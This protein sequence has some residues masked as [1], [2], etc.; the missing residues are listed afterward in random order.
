M[1]I[2]KYDALSQLTTKFKFQYNFDKDKIDEGRFSETFYLPSEYMVDSFKS[3]LAGSASEI[4]GSDFNQI[5]ERVP[6]LIQCE[7]GSHF[8]EARCHG[9]VFES[10]VYENIDYDR[11]VNLLDVEIRKRYRG[12]SI[13][14]SVPTTLSHR[15]GSM[16][17]K[18]VGNWHVTEY[19]KEQDIGHLFDNERRFDF[20]RSLLVKSYALEEM[21]REI[22]EG[23]H[24]W[25]H[26][27]SGGVL[28][29]AE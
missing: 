12:G 18:L 5:F 8:G 2:P 17:E 10:N 7:E 20:C 4:G 26:D 9:V 3:V 27:R 14:E 11:I 21:L 29:T 28:Q 19:E 23:D 22:D 16:G 15:V 1:M 13:S 6:Y 24:C 25:M